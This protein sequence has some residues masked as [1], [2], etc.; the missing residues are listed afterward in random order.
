MEIL[1]YLVIA[2]LYGSLAEF[3]AHKFFMHKPLFKNIY[4]MHGQHHR[5]Y[6]ANFFNK[7]KSKEH[8]FS[9]LVLC[10]EHMLVFVLPAVAITLCFNVTLSVTLLL[11][12]I[13]H[14]HFYNQVHAAMHTNSRKVPK[15][16]LWTHFMHHAHP[17]KW[18]C[19]SLPFW[20]WVF[21][22]TCKMTSKDKKAWAKLE[23]TRVK[24]VSEIKSNILDLDNCVLSTRYLKNGVV[25][26][27]PGF[28]IKVGKE[29]IIYYA[30]HMSWRDP[31]I[32]AKKLGARTLVHQNVM[33]FMWL[34]LILGPLFGFYS[35]NKPGNKAI[36]GAVKVLTKYKQPILI[37]P[38]GVTN[39]SNQP[40]R[41]FKS[42]LARIIEQAPEDIKVVGI[43]IEYESYMPAWIEKFPHWLQFGLSLLHSHAYCRYN[44]T[45]LED[46]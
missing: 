35:V 14:F 6:P 19:V 31:I 8:E 37:F 13:V 41:P 11:F 34:G 12:G 5:A 20:D 28:L 30:N 23:R 10:L 27:F 22:T 42:G 44:I 17:S 29:P 39:L 15:W 32:L 16:L 24:P 36:E 7:H 25:N 4:R 46:V 26:E 2:Y 43:K 40:I 21:G 9:N 1:L 33:N 38:E 45:T 3:L 18:F